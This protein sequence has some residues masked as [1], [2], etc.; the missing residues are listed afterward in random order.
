MVVVVV[1]GSKRGNSFFTYLLFSFFLFSFFL[2]ELILVWLK[3]RV[4]V[5]SQYYYY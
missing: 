4:R 3:V 5:V 2:L 1:T